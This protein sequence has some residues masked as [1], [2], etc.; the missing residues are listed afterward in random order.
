MQKCWGGEE[1][2]GNPFYGMTRV[3]SA[4]RQEATAA[5]PTGIN[6]LHRS[7]LPLISL[8]MVLPFII[9]YEVGTRYFTTAALHGGDQQIIAF[10]KMQAFFQLMGGSSRHLPAM[11]VV[12]VLLISHIVRKDPWEIDLRVLLGMVMESGVL[13][14]PLILFGI[15]LPRYFPL[16][17]A[18]MTQTDQRILAFGAG[19]YEEFCFRLALFALLSLL[20]HDILKTKR[21]IT[22]LLVVG[23]SAISFSAYHYLSPYEHFQLQTFV[24][25][26]IAGG[27]FGILFLTRGFGIT[28]SCHCFYDLIITFL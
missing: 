23:T 6:Y 13:T 20:F 17:A 27:Y 7:E 21:M 1:R 5:S 18:Q 12:S 2:V 10:S 9:L 25:R 22:N 14:I 3:A 4:P 11:A 28:A 15:A 26:T 16:A 8:V 19:V 24:F